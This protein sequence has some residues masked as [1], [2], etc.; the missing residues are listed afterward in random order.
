MLPNIFV[1]GAGRVG[2]RH[3]EAL[4]KINKDINIF[5]VD[6]DQ[7]A[8]DR[9]RNLF[10]NNSNNRN[11]HRIMFSF[12]VKN[13]N[14]PI[15][16]A[17][18]A[19]NSDIRK[20]V[21]KKLV[22]NNRIK[23]LILEK[24]V[25]QNIKDFKFIIQLLEDKSIQGFVNCPRRMFPDYQKLRKILKQKTNI[26]FFYIDTHWDFASNIIH[27][28][29][30]FSYFTDINELSVENVSL[31]RK[32]FYSK[33]KGFLDFKGSLLF[34]T[35]RGDKLFVSDFGGS[36]T[37][38]GIHIEGKDFTYIIFEEDSKIFSFKKKDSLLLTQNNFSFFQQSELTNI[39][40]EKLI[41]TN[42]T[43]LININDSYIHHKLILNI[44]SKHIKKYFPK[45]K[46]CPIT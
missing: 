10:F 6:P 23:F 21:I 40:I 5:V 24:I 27:M 37:N 32:K 3:V 42:K 2:S 22:S 33:R 14:Q 35:K 36:K 29:D 9:T 18:I 17:I 34:N 28:L 43:E 15:H 11:K 31:K 46:G 39:L 38:G 7:S 41:D 13:I 44:F 25:T 1:I 20:N 12:E 26:N 30:L 8:L 16:T 45:I 19:T 4:S